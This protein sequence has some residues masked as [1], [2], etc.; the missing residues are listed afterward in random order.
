MHAAGCVLALPPCNCELIVT[1]SN[2]VP[3]DRPEAFIVCM[4]WTKLLGSHLEVVG[5]RAGTQR[6]Q[7]GIAPVIRRMVMTTLMVL[8]ASHLIHRLDFC[9]I[10]RSHCINHCHTSR[11]QPRKSQTVRE[12]LMLQTYM[13]GC[14]P[15]IAACRY[16]CMLQDKGKMEI[17]CP[18]QLS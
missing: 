9:T 16:L 6:Q 2:M 18:I 12:L 8:D 17:S 11:L 14:Y 13:H 7:G 5:G 15:S 3:F 1:R 10:S 4:S